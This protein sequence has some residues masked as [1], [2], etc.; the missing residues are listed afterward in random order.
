LAGNNDATIWSSK[1]ITIDATFG[2]NEN[3]E[4]CP[5]ITYIAKPKKLSKHDETQL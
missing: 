5:T 1:C 3:K 4:N 2:T